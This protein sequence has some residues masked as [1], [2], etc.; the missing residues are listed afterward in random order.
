MQKTPAG[1]S[2][3]VNGTWTTY[4]DASQLARTARPTK[5]NDSG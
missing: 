1:A 5:A 4:F 3:L 2:S